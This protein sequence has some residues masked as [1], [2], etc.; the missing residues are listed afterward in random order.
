MSRIGEQ[1]PLTEQIA[2]EPS[3]KTIRR[4]PLRIEPLDN[5]RR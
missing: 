4:L 3:P 5:H 1:A 2:D